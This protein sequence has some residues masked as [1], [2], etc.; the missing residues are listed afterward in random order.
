MKQKMWVLKNKNSGKIIKI[1]ANGA[2]AVGF[3]TKN[4]LLYWVGVIEHDEEIKR[5]VF[6]Y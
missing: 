6:E 4:D 5:I 3:G 2:Y 1:W